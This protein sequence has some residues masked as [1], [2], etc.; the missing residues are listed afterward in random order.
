MRE[1]KSSSSNSPK[2]PSKQS[3]KKNCLS[4]MSSKP[5]N[6]DL[7]LICSRKVTVLT[8][9]KRLNLKRQGFV[10]HSFPFERHWI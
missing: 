3:K 8:Q 6:K 9:N 4:S 10:V 1:N 7:V 2:R 5:V